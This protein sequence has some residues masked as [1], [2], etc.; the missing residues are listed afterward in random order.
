MFDMYPLPAAPV[1]GFAVADPCP[2]AGVKV[3]KVVFFCYNRGCNPIPNGNSSE[4]R[5]FY[6]E[7]RTQAHSGPGGPHPAVPDGYLGPDPGHLRRWREVRLRQR[8]HPRLLCEAGGGVCGGQDRR[9]HRHR[10]PQRLRHHRLQVLPGHRR[11][12]QRRVRDRH[13][14]QHRLGEG[15]PV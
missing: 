7:Q 6:Y 14:H 11:R 9:V 12:E 13:G 8:V 1:H 2:A 15:R 4:R 5:S 10:L 3:Y